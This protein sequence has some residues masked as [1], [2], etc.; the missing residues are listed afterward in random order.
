MKS[1]NQQEL[2]LSLPQQVNALLVRC[3]DHI[4]K[5]LKR[6]AFALYLV[7]LDD[8][9]IKAAFPLLLRPQRLCL[10]TKLEV[11]FAAG[12]QSFIAV[13]GVTFYVLKE[14]VGSVAI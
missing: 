9:H 14:L 8:F 4:S 2:L 5:D 3:D 10:N 13:I 11:E 7:V 6:F 1:L 12:F